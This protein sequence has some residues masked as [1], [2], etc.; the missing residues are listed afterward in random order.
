[1]AGEW[2]RVRKFAPVGIPREGTIQIQEYVNGS[3]AALHDCFGVNGAIDTSQM[4][5]R[6]VR[7]IN[8][9]RCIIYCPGCGLRKSFTI[10][11]GDKPTFEALIQHLQTLE[12]EEG[13]E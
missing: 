13:E 8:N 2:H 9:V 10:K 5:I 6:C 1:M 12:Y 4:H 7:I 11:N 3:V